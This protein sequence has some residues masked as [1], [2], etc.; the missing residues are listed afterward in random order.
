ME[1]VDL[2]WSCKNQ[3]CFQGG[4][5]SWLGNSELIKYRCVGRNL[6]LTVGTLMWLP[7]RG[8]CTA[9]IPVS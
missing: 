4:L 3:Q 9:E 5:I 7:V 1:M 2:D 6:Y 8:A